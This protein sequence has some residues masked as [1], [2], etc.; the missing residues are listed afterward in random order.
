M[1]EFKRLNSTDEPCANCESPTGTEL[2][3]K[4]GHLL[5]GECIYGKAEQP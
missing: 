1:L 4:D 5:C 2:M 3:M